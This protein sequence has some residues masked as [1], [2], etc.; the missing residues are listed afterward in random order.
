MTAA[1]ARTAPLW[2]YGAPGF[3]LAFVALPL[4]VHLSHHY[5]QLGVPLATL[6]AVLLAARAFDAVTDPLL[7]AWVD[8]QFAAGP[9]VVWRRAVVL[10]AALWL[11]LALLL[12]PPPSARDLLPLWAFAGAAL[13]TLAYSALTIAHQSWGARLGGDGVRQSRIVAWREGFALAGVVTASL[14]PSLF[15]WH[16]VLVV[17]AAALLLG[18]WAWRT[19]PTPPAGERP[20]QGIPHLW[21]P[22][23]HGAFRRLLLIFVLNGL[24]S[25]LPATLLLFFVADRLRAPQWEGLFLAT[26]FVAA[27]VGLPGWLALVR[28]VGVARAWLSGMLLAVAVFAW[29]GLLEAGEVAAFVAICA[30]SGLALGADLALPA[31]LLATVID[32]VGERHTGEGGYFG[33]WNLASKGNLALAAGV[34]LPLL[35]ALGYEPGSDSAA[36]LRALTVAYALLPCALKLAAAALLWHSIRQESAFAVPSPSTL[37][38][39]GGPR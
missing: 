12:F 23:R 10:A 37:A 8:R 39:P 26:Y 15:G 14:L 20:R 27:A 11:T 19:A 28:R 38:N 32:R 16:A 1:H 18:L 35:A 36:G 21:Q 6:G 34:G 31:A 22:W 25:A 9:V 33:W 4:Y 5:A 7:G 2:R 30:L 13:T 3:A 24:A 29:A 17:L